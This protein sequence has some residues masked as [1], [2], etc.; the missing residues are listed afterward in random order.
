MVEEKCVLNVWQPAIRQMNYVQ[1]RH[2]ATVFIN[3]GMLNVLCMCLYYLTQH[4]I[5]CF[6]NIL[7]NVCHLFCI[8]PKQARNANAPH[9]QLHHSYT[10]A[11]SITVP[12]QPTV[13]KCCPPSVYYPKPL[14]PL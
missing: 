7:A 10:L 4:H 13:C 6:L 1:G 11:Q 3:M 2:Y 14:R 8:L 9:Y 5:A 12:A